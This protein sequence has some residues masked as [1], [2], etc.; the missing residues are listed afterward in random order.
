MTNLDNANSVTTVSA[1]EIRKR[2]VRTCERHPR[3]LQ[4][5]AAGSST[6]QETSLLQAWV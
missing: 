2:D 5:A 4:Q 1:T 6:E 3:A